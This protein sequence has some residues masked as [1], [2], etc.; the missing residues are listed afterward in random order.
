MKKQATRGLAVCIVGAS[1]CSAMGAPYELLVTGTVNPFGGLPAMSVVNRIV[2]DT[3]SVPS[4]TVTQ[5]VTTSVYPVDTY[6]LFF[7]GVTAGRRIR[8]IVI[9]NTV[10]G[11]FGNPDSFL[12]AADLD[13]SIAGLTVTR[14]ALYA[15][16]YGLE[17]IDD[18]ELPT[19]A[20]YF[21]QF[22]GGGGGLI[23]QID[24]TDGQNNYATGINDMVVTITLIPSPGAAAVFGAAGLLAFRRRR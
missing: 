13:A 1:T 12:A 23:A 21:D 24:F 9:E 15:F 16:D 6:D 17:A 8:T 19:D 20:R 22:T 10:P 18:T 5:N 3:D 14:F 2:Y 11:V 4:T 7:D